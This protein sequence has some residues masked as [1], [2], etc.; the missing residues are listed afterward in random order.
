MTF[1]F[2]KRSLSHLKRPVSPFSEVYGVYQRLRDDRNGAL[3]NAKG[4]EENRASILAELAIEHFLLARELRLAEAFEVG[5]PQLGRIAALM[6]RLGVVV[7]DPT[8]AELTRAIEERVEILGTS[9]RVNLSTA[10]VDRVDRPIVKIGERIFK[11]GVRT[12]EPPG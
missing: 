3:A 1:R 10:I 6:T 5:R 9:V 8:G 7:E 2:G 4:I 11:G 12:A